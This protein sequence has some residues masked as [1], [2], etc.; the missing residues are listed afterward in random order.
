MVSLGAP[1]YLDLSFMHAHAHVVRRQ[2][3]IERGAQDPD[4]DVS[5]ADQKRPFGIP[6]HVEKNF[7]PGEQ[8]LTAVPKKD[9]RRP[10]IDVQGQ[11]GTIRQ[12]RFQALPATGN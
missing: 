12:S 8:D 6:R 2:V 5:R 10:G 4:V 3:N 9:H 11:L 1:S 7:A